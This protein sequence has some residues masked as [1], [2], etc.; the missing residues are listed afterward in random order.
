MMTKK[1]TLPTI[2]L[3]LSMGLL[4]C[5][6]G[7]AFTSSTAVAQDDMAPDAVDEDEIAEEDEEADDKPWS[8][9][10]T[11]RSMVGQ[12]TFV[13]VSNDSEF[14]GDIDDGSGAFNRWNLV[15]SITP[16]YQLGDFNF[17][18]NLSWVQWLT[19]GGGIRT[20]SVAGGANRARE[21][22]FQ[23]VSGSVG[24]KSYTSRRF[25]ATVTPSL[26]FRLPGD[27]LSRNDTFRAEIGGGVSV[28]RTFLEDLTLTA[29]ISASRWFHEFTS[30]VVDIE[31]IGVDNALYR[32]G[33]AEDVTPGRFSIGGYNLQYRVSP[34]MSASLD[35]PS[36]FSTSIS[37]GLH[38]YYTYSGPDEDDQFS[39]EHVRAGR[40]FSQ[41]TATAVAVNYTVNEWV[42]TTMSLNT[43]QPPKTNDN[44]SFRFPFWNFS[45]PAS[46]YSSISF[47]V[48]GT[49]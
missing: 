32:P 46:N 9:T 43:L 31:T 29:G 13:S 23:D 14:A 33:E 8:V 28:T 40:G 41:V 17:S 26:S 36:S 48:E 15:Y 11:L 34:T 7:I 5:L 10:M 30:P 37:Y 3:K 4:V 1:I 42:T 24:W 25:D 38:N 39:G 35:L 20:S 22:R 21:F 44:K 45:G 2:G 18:L 12:G 19:E 6:L 49:Y 47:I 27:A 16:S